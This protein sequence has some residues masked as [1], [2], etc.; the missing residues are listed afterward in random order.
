MQSQQPLPRLEYEIYCYL[1]VKHKK[2]SF[3]L[4]PKLCSNIRQTGEGSR[5]SDFSVPLITL[6]GRHLF[7]PQNKP[8]FAPKL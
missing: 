6:G 7:L 8:G 1:W 5:S 3:T 2:K 4:G